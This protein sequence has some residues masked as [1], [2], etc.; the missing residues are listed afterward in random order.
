M[1]TFNKHDLDLEYHAIELAFSHMRL[2]SPLALKK[3]MTSLDAHG[4]LMPVTVVPATSPNRYIL[5]DGYLRV[6]AMKKLKY[7]IVK[8]EIWECSE[9]DALL[10][11]LAQ[12]GQRDWEVFEEAHVLRELQT[13]HHLSQEQIAKKIGRTQSWISHRLALRTV[14][15][16]LQTL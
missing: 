11:L 9:A 7:D 12:Q 13:R 6:G 8:A 5:I 2:A 1:N 4:Q 10:F 16:M 15:T 3:M 14:T